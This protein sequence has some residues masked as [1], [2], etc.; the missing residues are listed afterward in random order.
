MLPDCSHWE[1][2]A[3]VHNFAIRS[4]ADLVPVW[5]DSASDKPN[6]CNPDINYKAQLDGGAFLPRELA[7]PTVIITGATGGRRSYYQKSRG[8]APIKDSEEFSMRDDNPSSTMALSGHPILPM[9]MQFPTAC[10]VGALV[11]DLVYWR[12][13]NMMWETFSVWLITAGLIMGGVAAVAG[14]VDLLTNRRI[15]GLSPGWPYVLGNTLALILALVNAFVHSRDAYTSVIPE[16]LIL[17]VLVV[18]I[19]AFTSWMDRAMVYRYGAGVV[20]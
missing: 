9:F 11:T 14:A 12:T 5:G 8:V 13:A 4:S 17:S 6:H 20:Q 1:T 2:G 7:V 18:G 10:F 15:R 19:L 3:T 16:G